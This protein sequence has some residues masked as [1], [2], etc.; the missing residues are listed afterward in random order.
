LNS[1]QES[2]K[3]WIIESYLHR[4]GYTL[5]ESVLTLIW[6]TTVAIF[7]IGGAIGAFIA[8]NVSRRYG[9]RG[10]LLRAN[11]LGIIAAIFMCSLKFFIY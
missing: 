10:G 8:S 2:I 6:S 7:A 4:T 9:R 5:S 11:L 1:V 3:A